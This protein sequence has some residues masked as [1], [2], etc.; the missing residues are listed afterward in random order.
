MVKKIV[1]FIMIVT[2]FSVTFVNV[3]AA[4]LKKYTV[5]NEAS[6]ENPETGQT[7][8][9][10][11]N[12][13]IGNAMCRGTLEKTSGLEMSASENYVTFT[14]KTIDHI[15]NFR[16]EIQTKKGDP[17][18]YETAIFTRLNKD[19]T[20]KTEDY[21]IKIKDTGLLIKLSLFITDIDR[22]VI[23]FVKLNSSTIKAVDAVGT[24]SVKNTSS[25]KTSSKK[26]TSEEK[27]SQLYHDTVN[28]KDKT[29]SV[30][31]A[32][33]SDVVSVLLN[34]TES[35][36]AGL[37]EYD[38]DEP[39]DGD[40]TKPQTNLVLII[41]VVAVVLVA[42]GGATFLLYRKRTN[43]LKDKEDDTSEE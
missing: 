19:N 13:A 27:D 41:L 29:S 37:V 40:E 38:A 5:Q 4:N 43:M 16:C 9:G 33:S 3:N 28:K 23:F 11:T 7:E 14:L 1:V 31:A 30:D 24:S 42:L 34:A 26:V 21:R 8:D 6:Y 39:I 25:K 32:I 12:L 20:K 22:D 36:E 10:G 35:M 18:A 2:I 15:K 17:N